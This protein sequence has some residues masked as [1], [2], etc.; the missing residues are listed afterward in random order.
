MPRIL[1]PPP[2]A[3]RPHAARPQATK[4]CICQLE[5]NVAYIITLF[6]TVR[7]LLNAYRCLALSQGR[8]MWLSLDTPRAAD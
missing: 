8:T 2:T 4:L 7:H 6:R 1:P 3:Y 5:E